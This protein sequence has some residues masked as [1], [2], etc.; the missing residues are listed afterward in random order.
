MNREQRV[1]E[2]AKDAIRDIYNK[3]TDN[4][5][6]VV[7]LKD[8]DNLP[9][10]TWF[11]ISKGCEIKI[12]TA[13]CGVLRLN[14]KLKQ[15]TMVTGH[16]HLDHD[17]RFTMLKGEMADNFNTLVSWKAG[18][19]YRQHAGFP[20]EPRAVTDCLMY[21]DLIPLDCQTC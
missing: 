20:H 5:V 14:C 8:Y 6:T 13:P 2:F 19:V 4:K 7:N 9:R 15:G 21:I 11:E 3:F 16:V 12:E 17:E 18:N 10:G 1:L